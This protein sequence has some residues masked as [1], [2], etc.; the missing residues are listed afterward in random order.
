[1]Y[2]LW[3][4]GGW[5]LVAGRL[6]KCSRSGYSTTGSFICWVGVHSLLK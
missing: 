5:N 6:D 1:M 4:G 2:I 3:G